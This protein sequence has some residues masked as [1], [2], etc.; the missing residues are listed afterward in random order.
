M[1]HL[2]QN[3]RRTHRFTLISTLARLRKKI[4]L[5]VQARRYIITEPGV[6]YRFVTNRG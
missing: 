2:R 4:G 3:H 6:G 5:D 1:S